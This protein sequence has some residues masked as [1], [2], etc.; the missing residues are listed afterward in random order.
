MG[1][2]GRLRWVWLVASCVLPI[3][4]IGSVASAPAYANGPVWTIGSASSPTNFAPGDETG[5]DRY[6]LSVVDSGGGSD[7]GSPIEV[8]D[9]LPSGLTAS[10]IRGEDLGNGQALLCSVTPKP[11]CHYEGFEMASG[12]V[13]RI[14][15]TVKVSSGIAPSVTN[16]ASVTGG[17]A[18]AGAKTKDPTTISSAEASF[19]ISDFAAT[20]SEGQAGAGVNLTTG[21]TFNQVISGDETV[22]AANAKDVAL[23]LPPGFIANPQAAPMCSISQVTTDDCPVN[24]AVGVAFT[25]S[26]AGLGGAPMPYS[27]LVYNT[28]PAL[29]QLGRLTL[30]LPGDPVIFDLTIRADGTYALRLAA[31]NLT[32]IESLISMTMTLWG[33]PVAYDGAG[34]DHVLAGGG[35]SFGSFGSAEPERFLTGA[36]TCG[37]LPDSS[38][39]ADSWT[40]M[41]SFVEAS[42]AAP[43]LTGCNRLP[44]DPSLTVA[45]DVNMANEPSGYVLDLKLPQQENAD[46][47]ASSDLKN[48]AV[49]LPQGAGISLSA[50]NGMLACSEAQAALE[51]PGPSMCPEAAK[52]GTVEVKTPLLSNPLEGAVYLA[53]PNEN[54]F[55]APL[56]MY[57]L[58]YDATTGI[59]I[60]LAGQIEA[61]QLTGQVTLALHELPQLPIGELRLHFFG[62]ARALLS[63]PPTCGLATST[64]ELVPWSANASAGASSSFE[65]E[66]GADGMACSAPQPFSPAFLAES[67][68]AGEADTFDSLALFVSREEHDQEQ[69]LGR[70]SFE[71]PPALAQMFAGVLPCEEPQASQGKC[72]VASEVGTVAA[73]AGLSSYPVNLNGDIYL[74]GPYEGSPQSLSIALPIDPGPLA[75][76][77]AVMRAGIQIDPSTGRLILTSGQLPTIVD[78]V[79]LH[80]D[81]FL[82]QLDRG[83]FRIDPDGCESLAVT[84]TITSAQNSSV[85]ISTDP[86][87]APLSSCPPSEEPPS[88]GA[89][90][91]SVKPPSTATVALLTTHIT[92]SGHGLAAVKLLCE[93]NATCQGKLVLTSKPKG[94]D[95]GRDGKGRSKTTVIGTANFSIKAGTTATVALK[96]NARGKSL[97]HV[98]HGRLDATLTI[99]KSSPSPAQTHSEGVRLVHPTEQA[100]VLGTR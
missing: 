99:V 25:S 38:L 66:S 57:L 18:D 19:G 75:L 69:E 85:Q 35:Q 55:K 60:K 49:T 84:G 26:S 88:E 12:D 48:A 61:N 27:S 16:T 20:W 52:I 82:L 54:P 43:T 31:E 100:Q 13:L 29:G 81:E 59:S 64:A 83:Q 39:S 68:T 97:V 41:G 89:P 72:P 42:A 11:A 95:R 65:I 4:G 46:G 67:K 71:A 63:T 23:S 47:L 77:T 22:P 33:L 90:K 51:S 70:I 58:A 73:T 37:A 98:D 7:T 14:E 62:G 28:A 5:N 53:T 30:F 40:A 45:A 80:L 44:F 24:S 9:T 21:F 78:G 76:G 94:K 8:S 15:I 10:A 74:A 1:E 79:P 56:A 86:L 93:G 32:Q 17:G 36:S 87:G 2:L 34:P 3:L 96:L 92:T 91:A 50:A 6:V